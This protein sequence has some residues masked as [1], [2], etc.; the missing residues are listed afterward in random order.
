MNSTSLPLWG[1]LGMDN[2]D[3]TR[4]TR[5]L[6]L[7]QVVRRFN[8]LAVPGLGGMRY[9]KQIYLAALGIAVAERARSVRKVRNIEVAN[10]IEAISCLVSFENNNW[11][12]DPKLRGINKLKN[13]DTILFS[14]ARKKG[15]YVTQPMRMGLV[16][17]LPALRLVQ[18]DTLRYNSFE[19]TAT[20][21]LLV[22]KIS[23]K[24]PEVHGKKGLVDHLVSWVGGMVTEKSIRK[25]EK[26]R[27][28][29]SPLVRLD[30]SG[31]KLIESFVL[32]QGDEW[33]IQRRRSIWNWVEMDYLT[34]TGHS[35]WSK[36]PTCIDDQHWKDLKSGAGF[37]KVR[38][39]A[40]DLLDELEIII[41]KTSKNRITF[42]QASEILKN[43]VGKLKK[44]AQYFLD[45]GHDPSKGKEAGNFCIECLDQ[46]NVIKT[47]V[48]R[49]NIG[50][51]KRDEFIVPGPAFKGE[52]LNHTNSEEDQSIITENPDDPILPDNISYRVLN[53]YY[54]Q[55][56]LRG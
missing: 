40:L 49:D 14:I 7:G 47:L 32:K 6:R 43:N 36:R 53:M 24:Y 46:E 22:D 51:Q 56:D 33:S 5:T 28:L 37:F 11:K 26:V 41:S 45:L 19:L 20:G 25:N 2:I 31:R 1:L 15:F 50:L 55:K 23:S 38:K 35:S 17:V 21:Y 27:K 3:L 39:Q 29:L 54:L 44:S 13:K 4:R 10:A 18:S 8:E 30:N 34:T 9:A 16:Q 42:K 12:R 52:F 48:I